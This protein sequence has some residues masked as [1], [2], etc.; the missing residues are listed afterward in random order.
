[1]TTPKERFLVS[2]H[3]VNFGKL[4]AA[5][6]FDTACD[7]ALLQLRSEMP[8]NCQPGLLP[9]PLLGFDANAQMVGASRVLEILKHIHEPIKPP[10]QPVTA[11]LHY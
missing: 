4:V 5:E 3:A 8:V 1:M 11:K 6:A 7:Y 2:G 9:D 10:N